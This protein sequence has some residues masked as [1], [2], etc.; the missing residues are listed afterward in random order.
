MA[1]VVGVTRELYDVQV[2][3]GPRE[4]NHLSIH[5]ERDESDIHII[6]RID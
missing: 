3:S 6:E 5:H 4:G 1:T 2:V